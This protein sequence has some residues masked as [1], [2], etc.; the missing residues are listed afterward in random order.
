MIDRND[1][2]ENRLARVER[3]TRLLTGIVSATF[4]LMCSALLAGFSQSAPLTDL[5]A[6]IQL[7]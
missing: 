6:Q 1:P 4:L 5:T 3:T 2:I 7:G